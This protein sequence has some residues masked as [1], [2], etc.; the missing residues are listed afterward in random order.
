[1]FFDPT[2]PDILRKFLD[3]RPIG[4]L[5]YLDVGDKPLTGERTLALDKATRSLKKEKK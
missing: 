3:V 4:E 2:N 5:S 1:M